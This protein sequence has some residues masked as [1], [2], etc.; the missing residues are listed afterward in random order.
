MFAASLDALYGLTRNGVLFR[1]QVAKT[2][3]AK[4][5]NL[6]FT[7]GLFINRKNRVLGRWIRVYDGL[8]GANIGVDGTLVGTTSKQSLLINLNDPSLPLKLSDPS[9]T[10]SSSSSEPVSSTSQQR[11]GDKKQNEDEKSGGKLTSQKLKN[12]FAPTNNSKNAENAE[13]NSVDQ[14][15]DQN[16]TSATTSFGRVRVPLSAIPAVKK[17]LRVIRVISVSPVVKKIKKERL[18]SF[19][20]SG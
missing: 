18:K 10:S 16:P 5:K 11:N 4:A 15:E 20:E 2:L 19:L 17:N 14:D 3:P 8:N 9:I 1:F 12:L 6:E 7:C 13:K